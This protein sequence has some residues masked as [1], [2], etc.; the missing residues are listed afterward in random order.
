MVFD[1]SIIYTG[2]ID[3]GVNQL[4]EVFNRL[5]IK[6]SIISGS[7][8]ASE[9]IEARKKYNYYSMKGID[10][11]DANENGARILI[12]TKAGTEGVDTQWTKN[13]FLL[14]GCWNEAANEQIIA[15][16]IRFQ[17]HWDPE[18]P[19]K[20]SVVNVF[21]MLYIKPGK[22]IIG[23]T[24]ELELVNIL[25]ESLKKRTIY[26]LINFTLL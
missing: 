14:D 16:A 23:K 10:P 3:N 25:N 17:S 4:T 8:N 12:I 15:R 7:K 26:K 20:R 19:N 11:I 5:K 21:R 6:Y 13:I 2:L 9:K 22:D 24:T 18:N 1:K